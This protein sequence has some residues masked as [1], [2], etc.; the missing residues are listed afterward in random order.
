M[1]TLQLEFVENYE[2]LGIHSIAILH[3]SVEQ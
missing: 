3:N 2:I 1:K